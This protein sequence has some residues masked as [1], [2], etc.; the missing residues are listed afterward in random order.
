MPPKSNVVPPVAARRPRTELDVMASLPIG[1]LAAMAAYRASLREHTP[2]RRAAWR[3]WHC[4][5]ALAQHS[6]VP[7]SAADDYARLASDWQQINATLG[8]GA[9]VTPRR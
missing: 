3:A 4:L 5:R 1:A 7:A 9:V 8:Q 2:N 6:D